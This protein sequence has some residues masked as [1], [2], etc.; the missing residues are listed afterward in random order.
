VLV[1]TIQEKNNKLTRSKKKR[2]EKMK[3]KKENNEGIDVRYNYFYIQCIHLSLNL[4]IRGSKLKK[5]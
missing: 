4:L 3:I 1:L 2:E 5:T